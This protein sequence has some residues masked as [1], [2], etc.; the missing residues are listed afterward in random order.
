MFAVRLRL[1]I[2]CI[3]VIAT[4]A[5][6][7]TVVEREEKRLRVLFLDV[8]QGD[9]ILIE[10]PNG[11]QMLVD[12]GA[13]SAVLRELAR[14]MPFFDRSIDV[15]VATHPDQDHIGG[16]PEVLKR[17]E[18]GLVLRSGAVNDTAV[19]EALNTVIESKDMTEIVVRRGMLVSLG[20]GVY[21]EI[22]FPDRDVTRVDPNDASVVMRVVYG[23]SEFLLTGDAPQAIER[24][25]V[26]LDGRN[27]ESDV[28]K[29]GHHGSN[30]SST[31][32]FLGFVDPRYAV[33]SAGKDNRYGHPHREVVTRLEAVGAEVLTTPEEGTIGFETDGN[34]L[35]RTQ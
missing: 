19:F 33:V 8:G 22:L 5:V 27:L 32:I 7:Y 28:L 20:G 9:A 23:E 30:T 16:L 24:Y 2:L 6:W 11:N 29:V 35:V 18:V 13:G 12:G 34:V 31:D 26:S 1:A 14:A 10:A 3:L 25:L 15:V 17:F 4:V 21:A